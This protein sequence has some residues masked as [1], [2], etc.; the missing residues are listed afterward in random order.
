MLF[1]YSKGATPLSPDEI[2]NLIPSHITTQ[3]QLDEWEQYNIVQ[4]TNWALNTKRK[5]LL[6]INFAKALHKQMFNKTWVWAGTFRKRQTNIGIA[7]IYIP[8][9][10]KLLFDDTRF[11]IEHNSFSLREIGVR[12]H[13]RLVFIH[14]FP[15]GNGRFSRLMAE[16][17]MRHN[18]QASFTWGRC[19]LTNDSK[20][21]KKYL[22]ALREAD[23]GDYT[24]LIKFANN[25]SLG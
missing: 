5:E 7:S 12:L 18:G 20:I 2:S 8:Q 17:L 16:L 1:K 9:E 13:H 19:N 21:R 24:N 15:N 14:P 25:A 3:K 11:Q 4:G 6:S 23:N 10:L 22:S